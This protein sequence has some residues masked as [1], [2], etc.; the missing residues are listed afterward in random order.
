MIKSHCCSLAG[1][2][3]DDWKD[4]FHLCISLTDGSPA[5]IAALNA[6]LREFRPD[7]LHVLSPK[8][9]FYSH[10]L[11]SS[12]VSFEFFEQIEVRPPQDK[13]SLSVSV[14]LLVD[15]MIAF[16]TRF[17]QH[18]QPTAIA[19]GNGTKRIETSEIASFWLRNTRKPVLAV[20]MVQRDSDPVYFEGINMEVS[21]PTG[22][23]CAERN[24]I[25]TAL[26]SD[27][28]LRRHDLKMIAVLSLEKVTKLT[29]STASGA[30]SPVAPKDVTTA[31]GASDSNSSRHMHDG[32]VC[33]ARAEVPPTPREALPLHIDIGC[34]GSAQSSDRKPKL[35]RCGVG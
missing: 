30:T 3:G 11:D 24:C 21:M 6:G 12:N 10:L 20:L 17:L 29:A 28:R 25:G 9:F 4:F 18:W 8:S 23:L 19:C 26:A 2:L 22:S 34:H 32:E 14:Q 15:K 27:F 35:W 5:R 16:K 33:D 7:Y 31:A 13:A 1:C